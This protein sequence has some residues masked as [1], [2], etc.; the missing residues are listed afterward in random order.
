[1]RVRARL[2]G[3][4]RGFGLLETVIA[5]TIIFGS[6][7]AL[8]YTAT[9]GFRYNQYARER[10]AGTGVAD[11]IME[12]ARGLAYSKVTAG[13]SSTDLSSD[14]QILNC[15]GIYYFQSCPPIA[16]SEKIVNA[17][18]LS[19]T[20][21]LVPHQGTIA[22]NNITYN[23]ATY[24]T[25]NSPSTTPYRV[26]VRVTWTS[27]AI[28]TAPNSLVQTQSYFWS[29]SGCVSSSTHPFA[30]PCQPFFFGQGLMPQGL[31]DVSGSISG[32]TFSDGRLI[33]TGDESDAQLEQV[34]QVQTQATQTAVRLV[35]GSGT[36]NGGGVTTGTKAADGDP[37]GAT[38]LYASQTLA[39]TQATLSS[40][41]AGS[42]FTVANGAG[43]SGSVASVIRAGSSGAP[44]CPPAPA[45]PETDNL[46]CGGTKVQQS[47][48]LTATMDLSGLTPNLGSAIVAQVA[49]P[50]A[51]STT[52]SNRT[53]VTGQDGYLQET[54]SRTIGTFNFGALPANVTAPVGWTGYLFSLTGYADTATATA[55][56]SAAAP[57][58]S[59]TGGTITYWN[60]SNG[61]LTSS[62]SAGGTLSISMTRTVSISG[63]TVV[64]SMSGTTHPSSAPTTTSTPL[65]AGAITRTDTSATVG[66]PISGTFT[67]TV[68]IN[69]S[70]V[71]NLSIFIDFGTITAKG[72]YRAAPPP[73]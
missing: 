42:S 63:Q 29:P 54:V 69:G 27:A 10:Q 65:G 44:A 56:T 58:A 22:V 31:I 51:A 2:D 50:S 21:P 73:G 41:A 62:A 46:P 48:A 8:A 60:G 7:A 67:Y 34:S 4:E 72:V 32:L 37:S 5:I 1:M 19:T 33:T 64:V 47:N 57:T 36:Q 11:R 38:P 17:T 61:Y 14:P 43:D 35:D 3:D 53:A 40:A 30:A 24:V 71:V 26:T 23:W 70:T 18:G 66:S 9:I 28:P 45:S 49:Q 20:V 12:E 16:G 59:V 15:S 55:G 6:L 68:T 13:L 52:F 39:G 25:N